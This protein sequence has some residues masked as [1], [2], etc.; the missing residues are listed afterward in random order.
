MNHNTNTLIIGSGA[1]AL[2][3]ALC[4]WE[5]GVKDILIVTEQWGGGTSNNAGSDKQTYYKMSLDPS[6]TAVFNPLISVFITS[7]TLYV[8][9]G[10]SST[11]VNKC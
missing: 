4:L 7:F 8:R 9:T 11:P 5:S 2:N 10:I 1:A 3:A 6:V